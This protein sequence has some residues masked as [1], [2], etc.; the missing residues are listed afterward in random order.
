MSAYI[1]YWLL[2]II[3]IP[4]IILAIWAQTK[5]STSFSKWKDVPSQKGKTAAEVAREIL[6]N[7]GLT[8]ISIEH[9]DGHLTDH[10]DPK[11]EKIALSDSV[12]NSTSIAA[13]GVACHEV[14]HALQDA[15]GYPPAK[16]RH[17]LVPVINFG[18]RALWP[19]VIFG[20]IFNIF[21]SVDGVVGII[22]ISAGLGFYGLSLIFSL[23]TLPT[24][25]D[26]SKRALKILKEENYL[27]D[28]IENKGAK[29]VLWSAALTYVADLIVSI[30]TVLRF[31][32][33]ILILRGNR[34]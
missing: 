29:Q 23:I 4:G 22:F 32:L 6:D 10:Y 2:G 33:T 8:N 15:A 26:A 24:E 7:N 21:G 11:N 13:V 25:F 31:V 30:L 12:Y 20:F 18:S 34:D 9:V 16:L 19:L 27:V 5:V 3:M 28:D 17:V 14:G 1:I